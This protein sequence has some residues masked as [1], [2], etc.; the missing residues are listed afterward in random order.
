MKDIQKKSD[1][2]LT[3]FV[4]DARKTVREERF[5]DTMSRKASV[6]RQAKTDIARAL[7]ELSTRRRNPETK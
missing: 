5:K 6:I 4:A 7:T 3:Q 2:E 1:K